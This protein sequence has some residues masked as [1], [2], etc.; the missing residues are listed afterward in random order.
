MTRRTLLIWLIRGMGASTAAVVGLPAL[1]TLLSPILARRRRGAAWAPVGPMGRFEIGEVG[2]AAIQLP[3]AEGFPRTVSQ[4]GIF[5]WRRGEAE[6]VVFSRNC[7]DLSCP[8]THDPGSGWFFC[9]CH[10]GI[11]DE[12]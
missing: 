3:Q 7:T 12:E 5:V 6:L 8:V 9:P 11:F 1:A 4:V 2:K 10:G